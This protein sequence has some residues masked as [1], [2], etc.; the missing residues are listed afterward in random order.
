MVWGG[1]V[2]VICL[3]TGKLLLEGKEDGIF[4]SLH[5]SSAEHMV[6]DMGVDD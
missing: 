6:A 1:M 3:P 5:F 4:I 2:R